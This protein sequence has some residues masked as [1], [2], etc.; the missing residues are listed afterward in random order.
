MGGMGLGRSSSFAPDIA[1]VT[2]FDVIFTRT[3][4]HYCFLKFS[5]R[6]LHQQYFK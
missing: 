2:T 6:Q 3:I 1:K 5:R 4:S